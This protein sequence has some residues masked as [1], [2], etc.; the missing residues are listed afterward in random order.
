MYLMTIARLC[1]ESLERSRRRRAESAEEERSK[2]FR[3]H[4]LIYLFALFTAIFVLMLLY[5]LKLALS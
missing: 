4:P 3:Q 5:G 2:M 1:D